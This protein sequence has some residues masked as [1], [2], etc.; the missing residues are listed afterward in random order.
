MKNKFDTT[1][2]RLHETG[3]LYRGILQGGEG[4]TLGIERDRKKGEVIKGMMIVTNKEFHY[5][6]IPLKKRLQLAELKKKDEFDL[7]LSDKIHS[8]R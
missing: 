5:T 2:V 7:P 8:P 1:S 6:N 4:S 3:G